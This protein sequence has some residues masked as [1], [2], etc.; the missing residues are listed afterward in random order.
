[1]VHKERC[2]KGMVFRKS[3]IVD[4]EDGGGVGWSAG[5]ESD[6]HCSNE[7]LVV[8]NMKSCVYCESRVD[9]LY[10]LISTEAG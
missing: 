7:T 9:V 2:V 10:K 6:G 8:R 4:F 3:F 1:M 5:A